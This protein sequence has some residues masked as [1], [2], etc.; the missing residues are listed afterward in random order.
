MKHTRRANKRNDGFTLIELLI[1]VAIIAVLAAMLL[2]ALQRAQ[3]SARRARCASNLRQIGVGTELYQTDNDGRF[4]DYP[5]QPVRLMKYVGLPDPTAPGA[6][7]SLAGLSHI[8]YCPSA[9]G[10]GIA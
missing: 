3:E 1:V 4:P 10:K 2:P 6:F 7:N 5:F 8:F 9:K